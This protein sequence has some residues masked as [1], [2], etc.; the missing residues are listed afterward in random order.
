MKR[1]LSKLLRLLFVVL[2]VINTIPKSLYAEGDEPAADVQEVGVEAT[3]A[4]VEPVSEPTPE[5]VAPVTDNA[6]P[7]EE[8]KATEPAVSKDETVA[9]A[10][11]TQSD[12]AV[13]EEQTAEMISE[14]E[15]V[16][17]TVSEAE[18][19]EEAEAEM[20]DAEEEIIYTIY[21]EAS[22]NGLVLVD[23]EN[24]IKEVKQEVKAREEIVSVTAS[25]LPEGFTY[26]ASASGSQTD[27]GESKN[28]V[29][30]GYKFFD[31]EGNDKTANF[32]NVEKV[33]GKL[34]V[35]KVSVTITTG[36]DSKAYDG[37]ALTKDEA[38][39]TGLVNNE[40]ATVKA[41]GSQ[42][43]VG[44][45]DNTYS[46][47]WGTAKEGNYAITENLGTLTITKAN[48]EDIDRF[49]VSKP[50]DV[51]YNGKEQIQP[52]TITDTKTSK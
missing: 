39:I 5:P 27:A 17:E 2:L 4:E 25:G 3:P 49:D 14:N 50:E 48:I 11:E 36:S 45:S 31:A 38:S 37:T 10:E 35:N 12:A 42:T 40:T 41:N 30:D 28:V 44:S 24:P 23:P 33:E 22:E 34:T 13:S 32:T 18:I 15:T 19:K 47:S 46:I 16:E 43:E 6:P 52:V 7:A 21:F 8:S 9:T 29:N 51:I 20:K 1:V 26:E